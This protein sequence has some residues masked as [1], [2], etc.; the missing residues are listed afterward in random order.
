MIKIKHIGLI[1]AL[2]VTGAGVLWCVRKRSSKQVDI[3]LNT[4]QDISES[5]TKDQADD[6][7]VQSNKMIEA[8]LKRSN[9]FDQ[10]SYESDL[11]R[12]G[13]TQGVVDVANDIAIKKQR[14]AQLLRMDK[15]GETIVK[16]AFP[17][18]IERQHLD[19]PKEY[20]AFYEWLLNSFNKFQVSITNTSSR[21]RTVTLW[22]GNSSMP[23]SEPNPDEVELLELIREV[24]VSASNNTGVHPQGVLVNPVNNLVYV[25]N[26]LTNNISVFDRF[27]RIVR[28]IELEP[29]AAPGLNAPVALAVNT[30]SSSV[31]YGTVYVIGSVSNTVSV[32]D[33]SHNVVNEILVGK[34]PLD[35]V[36][37]NTN[38][39]LYI[40]NLIDDNVSVID[41][42]SEQVIAN[43][44]VG[45]A[46]VGVG[47][48]ADN[49][50]VFIANSE[51][52][53]VSVF[54]Q[55]N[56]FIT[57]INSVGSKP[58]SVSYHS[59]NN[60]LFVVATESNKVYPIDAVNYQLLSPID[61]GDKPYKS[62][63]NSINNYLYVANRI[64]D[65]FTIISP[66]KQVRATISKG[67]VNIGFAIDQQENQLWTTDTTRA[68][69]NLVGYTANSSGVIVS[70]NYQRDV[71]DF[72][73]NPIII[74]HTKWVLSGSE[75]FCSLT[76]R[77]ESQTGT[78]V[79]QSL[80]H[81]SYRSPR[82]FLNVSEFMD[83]EGTAIDGNTS[84]IFD[85]AP[86]Q[87]ISVLV[88][89]RQY[90][91]KN[92]LQSMFNQKIA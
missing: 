76:H 91:V 1:S 31:K 71:E 82:N 51:D 41:T 4:P 25:A 30:T 57:T 21:S 2:L 85:I 3:T 75:R 84:W 24:S 92:S 47:V 12:W 55:Q 46:P 63:F 69:L 72:I 89:F 20:A 45:N 66:D 53:S 86:G 8:A 79:S 16:Q 65:T 50:D 44:L 22:G 23:V 68:T 29:N 15:V 81:E 88:Y 40:T 54:D 38:Q 87:I 19:E 61:T 5:V 7:F 42:E 56:Q 60:E 73:H 80:S 64:D 33:L 13:T 26:Q 18:I 77:E 52:D 59:V 67:T 58:V 17:Q 70:E 43:L 90:K 6:F 28:L 27:G 32:I 74:K 37:N 9:I 11:K 49:G 83:L 14:R 10:S 34:R 36:Y 62:V 78:V 48:N 35:I 39:Q